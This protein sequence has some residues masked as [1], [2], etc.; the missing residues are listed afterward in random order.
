MKEWPVTIPISMEA[1]TGEEKELVGRVFT[2]VTLV[3]V[4]PTYVDWFQLC[5]VPNQRPTLSTGRT[6]SLGPRP[7]GTL[8]TPGLLG[9][10]ALQIGS[11]H[12]L[13]EELPIFL[14]L[15]IRS[16]HGKP[17]IPRIIS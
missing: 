13:H 10:P 2:N 7:R 6:M 17:F 8:R 9:F 14:F 4:E 11:L 1:A 16:S 3:F 15:T 12:H 5:V